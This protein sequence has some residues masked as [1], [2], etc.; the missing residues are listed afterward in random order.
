MFA[1]VILITIYMYRR[2]SYKV[3]LRLWH[4]TTSTGREEWRLGPGDQTLF[5]YAETSAGWWDIYLMIEGPPVSPYCGLMEGSSPLSGLRA[6]LGSL[7]KLDESKPDDDVW[8]VELTVRQMRRVI[9]AMHKR[10]RHALR[11]A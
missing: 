4:S 3:M 7:P 1:P 8:V 5:A 6:Y 2:T 11:P 10:P 9:G